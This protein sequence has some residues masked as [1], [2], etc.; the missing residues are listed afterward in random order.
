MLGSSILAWYTSTKQEYA[1]HNLVSRGQKV[2][3]EPYEGK[4]HVRFEVAGDGNQGEY[5]RRHPLTLPADRLQRRLILPVILDF[6]RKSSS[7]AERLSSFFRCSLRHSCQTGVA[8]G[9]TNGYRKRLWKTYCS[10]A[11]TRLKSNQI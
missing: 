10:L 6:H 5:P 4:P 9:Q 3:G 7:H 1:G 2:V 8:V 11:V